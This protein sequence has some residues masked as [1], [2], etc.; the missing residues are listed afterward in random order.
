MKNLK[1]D[2]RAKYKRSDFTKLTRGQFHEE[3]VRGT[4][5]VLLEPKLAKIFP[6][7]QA[8]NEALRGLLEL[9]KTA[10]GLTGAAKRTQRKH[11][12]A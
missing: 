10:T 2:M 1:N 12:A 8:V 6:T 5:V 4:S 9:A 11:A 7:S 3:A